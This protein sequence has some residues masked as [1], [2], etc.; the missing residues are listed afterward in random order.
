MQYC[1]LNDQGMRRVVLLSK[2]EESSLTMRDYKGT[3]IC[4]ACVYRHLN[5]GISVADKS[6]ELMLSQ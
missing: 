3:F 5:Q 6:A 2:N 1:M 4:G